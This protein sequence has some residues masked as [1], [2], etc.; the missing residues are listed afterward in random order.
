MNGMARVIFLAVSTLLVVSTSAGATDQL[1]P[2]TRLSLKVRNGRERLSFKSRGTF[3]IP[4]AGSADDPTRNGATLLLLNPNTNESFTFN[5]PPTHWLANSAHTLYK[6]RDRA[7]V[8]TAQ[9]KV[10]LIGGRSLRVSG[11]KVG[12][13]LGETSQGA[14]AISLT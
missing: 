13:T 3:T 11:R 7:L 14:L 10:A 12:I 4:V 6:Y 1:V 8:E 2:G 5:L 9:V